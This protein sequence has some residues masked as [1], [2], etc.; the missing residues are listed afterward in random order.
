MLSGKYFF[1]DEIAHPFNHLKPGDW[2]IYDNDDRSLVVSIAKVTGFEID[3]YATVIV[4]LEAPNT[5]TN[6]VVRR[7]FSDIKIGK[8]KKITNPKF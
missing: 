7:H 5:P 4:V 2:V 3:T 6:Q 8:M 1:S